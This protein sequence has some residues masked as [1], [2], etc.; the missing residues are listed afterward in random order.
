[1]SQA[2]RKCWIILYFNVSSEH[3]FLRS[4]GSVFKQYDPEIGETDLIEVSSSFSSNKNAISRV[5]VAA[6]SSVKQMSQTG[7]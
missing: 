2:L 6:C 3:V 7:K 1:M 5:F 4:L